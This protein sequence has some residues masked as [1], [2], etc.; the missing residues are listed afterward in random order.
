MVQE[1]EFKGTTNAFSIGYPKTVV[2]VIPKTITEEMELDIENKKAHFKI[3]LDKTN[4]QI[5]YEL[6]GQETK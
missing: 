2:V 4:K 1:L 3:F 5:I 6:I